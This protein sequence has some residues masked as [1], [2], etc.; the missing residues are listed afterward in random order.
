MKRMKEKEKLHWEVQLLK[1]GHLDTLHVCNSPPV[2][3]APVLKCP[4]QTTQ[5]K[6]RAEEDMRGVRRLQKAARHS[7]ARLATEGVQ[8]ML[9]S[10][11]L[12]QRAEVRC[13][14]WG[15]AS[16]SDVLLLNEVK[17]D[18]VARSL[19][20]DMLR[21]H[22]SVHQWTALTPWRRHHEVLQLEEL[23]EEALT[24]DDMMALAE[25][26][27][28]FTIYRVCT[29]SRKDCFTAVS[30]LYKLNVCRRQEREELT[31]LVERLDK[32]SLRLLCL[33]IRSATL[34]VQKEK[35]VFDAYWAVRQ[36][37]HTW[38][39][40]YSPCREEQAAA[41]L[42]G[43]DDIEEHME[44]YNL[45]S[46]PQSL[47]QLLVLTQQEERKQL[48][49][50]LQ[51]VTLEDVQKPVPA[52]SPKTSCIKRLQQIRS[53]SEVQ[54]QCDISGPPTEWSQDQLDRATLL[55]LA[56]LLEI[57]ERQTSSV[58]PALLDENE[59]L[60]VLRQ[61]YQSKLQ[62]PDLHTNLLQLL[63]PDSPS[64]TLYANFSQEQIP[65]QSCSSGPAQDQNVTGGL[66]ESQTAAE[67]IGTQ[68]DGVQ[69]EDVPDK[70]GVC[71]GCGATLGGLPYLEV[72]CVPDT[73]S[74]VDKGGG[75]HDDEQDSETKNFE[76][77][78]SLITLAWSTHLE[79]DTGQEGEAALHF[80]VQ[81][82]PSGEGGKSKHTESREAELSRAQ[83]AE[84]HGGQ[85][86]ETEKKQVLKATDEDSDMVKDFRARELTAQATGYCSTRERMTRPKEPVSA[87]EREKTM[88]KLVDVHRRVERKQQ[89]DRDRQQLRVQE[90]LSIIQ[91]RKADEDLFGPKHRERMKHL[92]KDIPQEDKSQQKTLVREQLE[93]LRRERSFIMQSR[94]I[95]NTA[96]FKE[97]LAPVH[98]QS[99]GSEGRLDQDDLQ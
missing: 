4:H 67:T 37:W 35:N 69:T 73:M 14:A 29:E 36:S 39:H 83:P 24:S 70:Q 54:P 51:E 6:T 59:H 65:Q 23:A 96:G 60:Q 5:S 16:C 32:E 90:R 76:E 20:A 19:Y 85:Q 8:S 9:A 89:R 47:L 48:V 27:G 72:L 95:R 15:S 58:L 38:P 55:L 26:P 30:L 2:T 94:R 42:R 84:T 22:H 62:T 97:L 61:E 87:L 88:R 1:V 41:L 44:D 43:D 53:S 91:S 33:Y 18:V 13:E 77:Q 82:Q 46:S 79:G 17:Y 78:D 49:R 10:P 40:V 63:N 52:D 56:D 45:S 3:D 28:A 74:Q 50:L 34:R 92:R 31:A 93:Q 57:Q 7:W 12:V 25:L 98:L 81:M 68:T 71:A 11:W 75:H 66:R 86:E 80:D 64:A 99:R 21:K